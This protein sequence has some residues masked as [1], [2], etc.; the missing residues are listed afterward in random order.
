VLVDIIDLPRG[1]AN[2]GQILARI[3]YRSGRTHTVFEV[4]QTEAADRICLGMNI[5]IDKGSDVTVHRQLAEQIVFLI[6]TGKLKPG[7]AL[8]SVRAMAMRHKIHPN[9][10]SE[11]YQNLVDR[12]W[13]K[14]QRG[15]KMTVRSPDEPLVPQPQ[16][17]DELIDAAVR[18]AYER[19]YT[20]QDLGKRM[21]ERLLVEPPDHVLLVEDEPGMRQLL[22]HELTELL[23]LTITACSPDHLSEN[24]GRAIGALVVSLP[25]RVWRVAAM[26][27]RGRHVHGLMPS[28]IDAHVDKIRKLRHP[29]LIIIVSISEVFLQMA[30]SVLAPFAGSRHAIE[31]YCLDDA[32]RDLSTTDLVFCDSICRGQVHAPHLIHYRLI[33]SQSAREISKLITSRTQ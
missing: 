3:H 4:S 31:V 18:G 2:L 26:L 10:V 17:L 19:G 5:R 33:S 13:I 7:D 21:Q 12:Y 28:S 8:P 6:A 15:K 25:G 20:M 1:V 29:S 22:L 11:V 9:T 32:A 27:P 30:R 23:S 16:D 14:R 24:Q